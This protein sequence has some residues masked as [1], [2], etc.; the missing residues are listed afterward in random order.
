MDSFRTNYMENEEK[1]RV[2]GLDTGTN[3]IGW[4]VIDRVGDQCSLVDSGVHIFTEGV[5]EEK[6]VEKS[7]AAE[8]TGYRALRRGYYR[9]KLRKIRM[10]RILSDLGWCP[11][12]SPALLSQWRLKKVYPV[13]PELM[14]WLE[15]DDNKEIT[16]YRYRVVCLHE[17]LDLTQE[18]QR[19]MLGRALYHIA[20]RRGFRSNRKD[21]S[22]DDE[23]GKVKGAI[24]E[25]SEKMANEGCE[26]LAEYFEKLYKEGK[27]I[28][29]QYTSRDSHYVKEFHAIC[30]RQELDEDIVKRIERVLFD[31]R[32]LKSQKHTVG[33][34]L[35]EPSKSRCQISHPDFEEMRMLQTI[36]QIRMKTPDDDML[37]PLWDEERERIVPLFQRKSKSNFDF[38]EIAKELAKPYFKIY[39]KKCYGYD[40]TDSDKAILF[41]YP[42]DMGVSGSPFT[43]GMVSA[44]GPE[45]KD[46]ID[47][48]YVK[49]DGKDCD[50][51]VN[52]VW[53]ALTF[54]DNDDKLEAWLETNLNIDC[55]TAKKIAGIKMP[56]AYASLS[57]KVI[58][59]ILPYMRGG[60]I[61]S[62]AVML[63]NI[64]AVLPAYER[65][66]PDMR[67]AAVSMA[68]ERLNEYD[69]KTCDVTLY[70]WLK[71]FFAEKY[72]VDKKILNKLYH[73]SDLE[74]Y[75]RVRPDG[76][77][78]M[79]LGSPRISSIRNPMAMRSLHRIRRVVNALLD[80]G[81]IDR[82]TEVYVELGR[83]L[84]D[85]NMRAAIRR[86]NK[87]NE[88]ARAK[89]KAAIESL[90]NWP[91]PSESDVDKA[92][93]WAEQVGGVDVLKY[94]L[95]SEQRAVCLYTGKQIGLSDIFGPDPQFDIEH[96]IPRSRGGDSTMENLTL[97]DSRF[98][99]EVK[100]TRLPSELANADEVLRRVAFMKE[101]S[102][103]LRKQIRRCR[104]N[105][106][107]DKG[108]KDA[109]IQKRH[110]LELQLAYWRNKYRRFEM[111]EVPEDFSRRQG[112][113]AGIVARYARLFLKSLFDD[114]SIVK[115]AA[116][117]DFRKAWKLQG[118]DEKKS[119]D[120][121]THHQVDAIV[122][123]CINRG[124]YQRLAASYH[125]SGYADRERPAVPEPWPGFV[126]D[127]RRIQGETL[128]SYDFTD[129]APKRVRR[130]IRFTGSHHV[131]SQP[132]HISESDTARLALHMD[133]NYGAIERDG[134]VKYVVRNM[135][136]ALKEKD[137]K[138]IVDPVVRQIVQDAFDAK[139]DVA[140]SEP[141]W[142]NEAK[143]IQIK[144][145][146][147]YAPSVTRP[148]NIRKHRDMSRHEYKRT[149]HFAND[150]NYCIAI[151]EQRLPQ[152]STAKAKRSF[153]IVSNLDAASHFKRGGQGTTSELYAPMDAKGY[154]L[155]AVLRQGDAVLLYENSPEE[156]YN[157]SASELCRRLYVVSGISSMVTSSNKYGVVQLRH[158]QKAGKYEK[159]KNGAYVA[160]E[161][162][163]PTI[164]ML[165]TQVKAL[166]Q[167]RDF[168]ID[169][170]GKIR[171]LKHD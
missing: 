118:V 28:R 104:T 72:H 52:D 154:P 71:D 160:G 77:G 94:E 84:N 5:K 19:F 163:R 30:R 85:A 67:K 149:G 8:R 14:Q 88:T 159:G 96:T 127:M 75:P 74:T 138:N 34:C 120:N 128:V 47:E 17:K 31:Q 133:T 109:I 136:S 132:A 141:I 33:R 54:F 44:L 11:T 86:Q 55:E 112:A 101:K 95:W 37:R 38:E 125:L 9:R 40:K 97:C 113:T 35:F 65:A 158:S 93:L 165:H 21:Q 4:A 131:K 60:M 69:K 39:G 13:T 151:Y 98:N 51:K 123:A 36:N 114:V 82:D 18:A 83:E 64:D 32:P 87:S 122:I 102:E 6:G 164:T 20:Q 105:P 92:L 168:T 150:G 100:K 1:K 7:K 26:F 66:N 90:L 53:H 103:D 27:R 171:F 144:K 57:H 91:D 68:I 73:P 170:L 130:R 63:A 126:D 153:S 115:G 99:R 155:M 140:F 41:N 108:R 162:L 58:S 146:R 129:N 70:Q 24:S 157:A 107:M 134:E 10:L 110:L 42:M 152:G 111:T 80:K 121:H 3:S 43:S 89:A 145:V 61:Y 79:R 117:A 142:M 148:L 78:R 116:T 76:Q 137:I 62:Y 106:A 169:V 22:N 50:T 143:G 49:G 56:S 81:L 2:L 139:G 48:K 23:T 15:T 29:N 167:N 25:L 12:L 161:T 156:V 46:V 45:W 59:K 16:P 124:D 119:R 166:V 147:C 135:I